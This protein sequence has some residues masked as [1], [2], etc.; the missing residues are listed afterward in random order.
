[1]L[2][3]AERKF[4][5][6]WISACAIGESIGLTTSGIVAALVVPLVVDE[7]AEPSPVILRAIMIGAG[8]LEGA[9]LG[10]AQQA[11]LGRWLESFSRRAWVLAT[12]L[13][14][15]AGWALGTVLTSGDTPEQPN[16]GTMILYAVLMGAALGSVM[17]IASALV[18]RETSARL[19]PFVASSAVAWACAMVVSYFGANALPAGDY[20]PLALVFGLVTGAGMGGLVGLGTGVV[21]VR[22]R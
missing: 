21:L 1:M 3:R 18:L 2:E 16:V 14:M 8:A 22:A 12:S 11:V 7:S 9:A 19:G 10:M 17:G 20:G 4:L 13:G 6:R 15:A 5:L